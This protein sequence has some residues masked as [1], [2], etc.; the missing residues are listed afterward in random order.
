MRARRLAKSARALLTLWRHRRQGPHGPPPC[1]ETTWLGT[2]AT[3][4]PGKTVVEAVFGWVK[5][6]LGFRGFLLRGARRV[7]G[8]W[9]LVCLAMNLRRIGKSLAW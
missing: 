9:N 5:Q 3:D 7:K 1:M 2:C 8:E 6:V 4:L